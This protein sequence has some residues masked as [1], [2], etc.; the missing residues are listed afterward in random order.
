[1]KKKC[2]IR[3]PG[4]AGDIFFCQKIAHEVINRLDHDIIWPLVP[5]CEWITKHISH[6]R[7]T[8]CSVNDGFANKELFLSDTAVPVKEDEFIYLPLE[9]SKRTFPDLRIMESKYALAS[10][11]HSDWRNYFKFKRNIQKEQDLF[12]GHLGLK[13]REDFVLINDTFGT[14][15]FHT[16][17]LPPQDTLLQGRDYTRVVSVETIMDFTPIDWSYTIEKAKKLI[18][19]DTCFTF[20]ID[21]I[22]PPCSEIKILSRAKKPNA[23]SYTD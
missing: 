22:E 5:G 7:I 1:M 3:Q 15:P 13:D 14:P 6:P 21:M 9:L 10:L 11:D 20:I 2:L 12:Y 23:P 19:V 8:F 18:F 4:G 16:T 17:R